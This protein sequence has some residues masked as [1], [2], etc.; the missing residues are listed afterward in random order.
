MKA[1]ALD[2][3]ARVAFTECLGPCSEANV[4]FLFL[5]ERPVWLRRMNDEALYDA[6][7][8]WLRETLGDHGVPPPLPSELAERS[9]AWT[10]GGDGPEPPVGQASSAA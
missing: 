5:D 10:G 6:L 9:F 7:F 3:Q 8:A 2:G 4:V 1:S